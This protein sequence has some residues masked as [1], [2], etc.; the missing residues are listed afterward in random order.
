MTNEHLRNLDLNLL[1][2][3]SALYEERNVTAAGERLGLAQSSVSHALTRLRRALGDPLFVRDITSMRPTPFAIAIAEPVEF[4]LANINSAISNA[5]IF[6]PAVSEREF[7]IMTTDM[8]ERSFLPP[9]MRHLREVAPGLK[10]RMHHRPSDNYRTM[11]ES[12]E[13]DIALGQLPEFNT[14]LYRQHLFSAG[15]GFAV[16]KEHPINQPLTIDK[17]LSADHL[18]VSKGMVEFRV[19]KAFGKLAAKRNIVLKIDH[20]LTSPHILLETDL[21]AALPFNLVENWPGIRIM[22]AP[23]EI[24]PIKLVQFWHRRT[25]NDNACKW[26]RKTIFE[27][28]HQK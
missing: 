15:I 24:E 25:H 8:G 28:F 18:V 5:R 10:I 16:R 13:T 6:E 22:P 26:L 19:N 11:L 1:K 14:G 12:G 20:Y 9:L 21:I 23:F 27:L 17:L 7:A 2:V 3:F 4:A